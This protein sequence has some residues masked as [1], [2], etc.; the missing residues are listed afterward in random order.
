MFGGIGFLLSGNLLVG[1]RKDLLVGFDP[2]DTERALPEEHVQE[3]VM[4]GR[5]TKGWVLVGLQAIE[6]DEKLGDW[7]QR[8]KEFVRSLPAK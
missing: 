1:V 3:F 6:A 7:I 4:R 2:D 8:A 5:S